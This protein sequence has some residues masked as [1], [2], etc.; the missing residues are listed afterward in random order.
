M[1]PLASRRLA[2]ANAVNDRGMVQGI[3]NNGV[4]LTKE[5]LEHATIGVKTGGVEDG[6]FHLH[7][8]GDAGFQL[9]MKV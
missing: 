3:G 9:C 2:E 4:L 6:I 7:I 5:R 8:A 1:S